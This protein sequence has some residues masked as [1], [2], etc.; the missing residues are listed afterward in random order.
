MERDLAHE[1]DM[2]EL[3]KQQLRDEFEGY[4]EADWEAEREEHDDYWDNY[5]REQGSD[6][7]DLWLENEDE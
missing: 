4:T 2:R 5:E 6:D 7:L 3:R 1:A